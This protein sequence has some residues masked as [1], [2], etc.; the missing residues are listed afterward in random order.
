M[1]TFLCTL[2]TIVVILGLTA[3]I[4]AFAWETLNWSIADKKSDDPNLDTWV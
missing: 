3:P 1:N 2:G 4:W